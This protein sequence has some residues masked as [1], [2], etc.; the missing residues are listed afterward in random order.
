MRKMNSD[1]KNIDKL[2][3]SVLKGYREKA[4]LDSWNRMNLALDKNNA[5][6]TIVFWKWMAA[7]IL[8]LIAFGS[9]YF[10]AVSNFNSDHITQNKNS[11]NEKVQN[12]KVTNVKKI[13]LDNFAKENNEIINKENNIEIAAPSSISNNSF[14]NNEEV[15]LQNI[16]PTSSSP[17]KSK[18]VNNNDKLAKTSIAYTDSTNT[19]IELP[20]NNED[21]IAL[22]MPNQDNNELDLLNEP[23]NE[24]FF[25]FNNITE[26]QKHK[27]TLISKW[28]IGARVA[29][30]RSYREIGFSNDNNI[31]QGVVSE[32]N[33]NNIEE[34]LSSYAGG[35]DVHYQL[36]EK[37]SLQSGMYFSK[38]G[39]VNNDALAFKQENSH[40]MLYKISTS[41][42]DIEVAFDRVPQDIKR[43]SD[44]KDTS[45]LKDLKNISIE[46]Q[47]ELFEVPFLI[48]YKIGKRRLTFN[49]S[50]GLSPAYVM[51]NS[52]TLISD[53]QKYDIGNSSNI[54]SMILNSSFSI[55][56]QYAFTKKLALNFEPTFKYSLNPINNNSSFKYHPYSLSWFT[57]VRFSF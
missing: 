44:S 24:N 6:K 54:N 32:S 1:N 12:S 14:A 48:G 39:Q 47:F 11:N 43:F 35:V 33:Y 19:N 38:I 26:D 53:E 34:G 51:S 50:G 17:E 2:F 28:E 10:Y 9:G 16:I 46:Q 13:E 49:L 36:N 20:T 7:A 27:N 25:D 29:S 37:W 31:S 8:I 5:A 3:K 23:I 42:G 52:S 57:G 56:I 18:P 22:I 4:P 55:G 41:T 21:D 40:Y 30:I 15:I 45:E